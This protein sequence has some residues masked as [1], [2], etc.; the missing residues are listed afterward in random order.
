MTLNGPQSC[1]QSLA[2]IATNSPL[3]SPFQRGINPLQTERTW[4]GFAPP[5][6]LL[7]LLL[8]QFRPK[9]A[10]NPKK[11][12]VFGHSPVEITPLATL[13]LRTIGLPL[14]MFHFRK[15]L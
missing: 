9:K 13:N 12:G 8:G 2:A 5:P 11:T 15:G 4:R 14:L 3:S 7:L 1:R 10:K 6:S